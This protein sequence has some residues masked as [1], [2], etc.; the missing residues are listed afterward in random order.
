MR[1]KTI[2]TEA[3]TGGPDANKVLLDEATRAAIP[4]DFGFGLFFIFLDVY[5][6]I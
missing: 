5:V 3:L 1:P 4:W 6:A 2:L